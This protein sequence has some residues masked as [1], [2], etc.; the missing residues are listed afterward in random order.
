MEETNKTTL[1]EDFKKLESLLKE[2]ERE[3]IGIE[4]AFAKYAEGM[5]LIKTCNE[6]IDCVE[7]KVMQLSDDLKLTPLDENGTSGEE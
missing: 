1:E 5:Q 6:K 3:D 2:M 7:K 4:D